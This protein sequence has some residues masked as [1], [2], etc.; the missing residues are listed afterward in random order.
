VNGEE[1][2]LT[3]EQI[4][5]L[6]DWRTVETLRPIDAKLLED[7]QAHLASCEKCHEQVAREERAGRTLL[8]LAGSSMSERTERCPESKVLYEL[9]GGF[10]SERDAER[11][12]RHTAGCDHC[13]PLLKRAVSDLSPEQ[14]EEERSELAALKSSNPKWQEEFAQRL[15]RGRGNA[16]V[17]NE[18]AKSTPGGR[19]PFAWALTAIACLALMLT[20]ALLFRSPRPDHVNSLLAEAYS[21][22]RRLEPRIP[23][24]NY[25]PLQMERGGQPSR[26]TKPTVLL[27]A[28]GIISRQLSR[29]PND[30]AWLQSKARAE[31][32]ER[33]YESAIRTLERAEDIDNSTT[34][35]TDLASAYFLRAETTQNGM[36]YAEAVESLGKVLVASPDDPIALYNRALVYERTSLYTQAID[37]WEHYLRIDPRGPWAD[38]ATRHL[39]A[40]KAKIKDHQVSSSEPLLS[41]SQIAEGESNVV[42]EKMD[43]RLEDYLKVALTEWLPHAYPIVQSKASRGL[44]YHAAL[45]Q[46]ANAMVQ[47]HQDPWLEDLLSAATSPNFAKAIAQLSEA[48]LANDRADVE[49]ARRSATYADRLF[50]RNVQSQAG[51]LLARLEFGVASNLDQDGT[52][53]RQATSGLVDRAF[54][55]SYHWIRAQ[56]QIEQGN[57][58]WLVEN[59]GSAHQKYTDA[60][61]DAARFGFKQVYLKARDHLSGVDGESGQFQSS[62][63]TLQDGLKDFWSSGYPDVRG[64]NFYYQLSELARAWDCPHLQ[65]AA[66]REGITLNDFS[67]D[68][69]QNA[70]AHSLLGVAAMG[71]HMPQVAEQ[72]FL[73]ANQLFSGSPKNESTRAAQLETDIRLAQA[74]ASNGEAGR[75]IGRLR[76]VQPRVSQQSNKYLAI[77]FYHALGDAEF[78]EGNTKNAISALRSAVEL[79]EIQLSSLKG[80][81]DRIAWEQR[82]GDVYREFTQLYLLEHDAS[83][84]L[85]IWEWYR[86]STLRSGV[87][88]LPKKLTR[89]VA[90][91]PSQLDQVARQEP[92]LRNTTVIS[93]A[94]LPHGLATW[95]FDDNGV[96]AHWTEMDPANVRSKVVRFRDL[97]ADPLSSLTTLRGEA[98]I[99]YGM[100]IAPIE[101]RLPADRTLVIE[102]DDQLNQLPI[103]VLLDSQGHYFGEHG[104][105]VSSLGLYYFPDLREMAKIT[106]DSLALV[107]IVS[108]P[109]AGAELGLAPLPDAISEGEAVAHAFHSAKVLTDDQASA[110]AIVSRLPKIEVFH[111]SGHAVSSEHRTGLILSQDVL[112][113]SSLKK[114]SLSNLQLAVFSACDTQNG[115]TGHVDEADSLVRTFLR[116]GVPHVVASRWTVDSAASREFMNLF[117]LHL[118][119]GRSVAQAVHAAKAFLR[120]NAETSHPFYWSAFSVFGSS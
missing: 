45:A 5:R 72:E 57:C 18:Q 99:L 80:E 50:A 1:K 88:V 27:E 74:E 54:A 79:A 90:S 69:A 98:R 60:S 43:G 23:G 51:A 68:K 100:F 38:E 95:V 21:I 115:S 20:G 9:V 41:P 7:A 29:H 113:A 106:A 92:F 119:S 55:K 3:I 105:M 42:V 66:W 35:L 62:W 15:A 13:G 17:L 93:Y 103:D 82:S 2:H 22:D 118:L 63:D 26:F 65:V 11:V 114:T 87:D 48:I 102:L 75:A 10:L 49:R 109:K 58:Q 24:A 59:L 37:D 108:N 117:Y 67:V 12:I 33:N 112:D 120:S 107:A 110:G 64:Y 81:R 73:R 76:R 32:L 25:A 34:L 53:C 16:K 89:A 77:L 44:A 28:E 86:G 83:R 14:T 47:H 61:R 104:S 30:P 78:H 36:D 94:L 116:A 4:A 39:N 6:A 85:E 31:L 56:A 91:E 46:L 19:W 52:K 96:E 97:C 40:T 8:A 111:F 71:A 101:K 70:M 84:A